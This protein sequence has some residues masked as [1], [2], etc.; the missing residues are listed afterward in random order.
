MHRESRFGWNL[1]RRWNVAV[2][3]ETHLD[4]KWILKSGNAILQRPEVWTQSHLLGILMDFFGQLNWLLGPYFWGPKWH[5]SDFQKCNFWFWEFWGSVG[6]LGD[7]SPCPAKKGK[8]GVPTE[9]KELK[10][11][12]AF[13]TCGRPPPSRSST[14]SENTSHLLKVLS[15]ETAQ[16]QSPSRAQA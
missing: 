15:C 5:F 12:V 4:Q 3:S 6:G 8:H 16:I 1:S 10:L 2:F 9:R 13:S 11:F 14:Q 7:C